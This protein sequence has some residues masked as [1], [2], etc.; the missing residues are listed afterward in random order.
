MKKLN[1]LLCTIA[2][3]GLTATSCSS[4]DDNGTNVG[5]AGTYV[6]EEVNTAQATDLNGD[7]SFSTNQMNEINC[8]DGSRIILNADNSFVYDRNRVLVDAQEG[9]Y[10]CAENTFTGTWMLQGGSGT[11]ATIIANYQDGNGQSREI[12][13]NKDGDEITVIQVFGEYPNVNSEGGYFYQNG[14][15]EYVFVK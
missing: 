4:D 10:A 9:T 8:Y 5:I 12:T 11:S 7:G 6:L 15:V 13:L 1:V 3:A 2:L 14:Q